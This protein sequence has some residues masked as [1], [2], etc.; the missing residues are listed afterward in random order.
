MNGIILVEQHAQNVKG[1]TN[2][3]KGSLDI[4]VTIGRNTALTEIECTS[5]SMS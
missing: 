1:S 3:L 4:H 2:I 5:E